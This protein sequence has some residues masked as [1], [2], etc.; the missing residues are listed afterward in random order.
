MSS[1]TALCPLPWRGTVHDE[2]DYMKR[3]LRL[4][5]TNEVP[6]RSMV[7]QGTEERVL[8]L[9]TEV[10]TSAMVILPKEIDESGPDAVVCGMFPPDDVSP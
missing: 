1:F 3:A 10:M 7:A 8:T 4:S 2:T 9:H 6:I 5:P